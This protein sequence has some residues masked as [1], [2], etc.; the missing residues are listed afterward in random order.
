MSTHAKLNFEGESVIWMIPKQTLQNTKLTYETFAIQLA[1]RIPKLKKEMPKII[2]I[3]YKLVND[4]AY[5]LMADDADIIKETLTIKN[6]DMFYI[7][8]P[9]A[10]NLHIFNAPNNNNNNN[11]ADAE[12]EAKYNNADIK[13]INYINNQI[14]KDSVKGLPHQFDGT[15]NVNHFIYQFK[16]YFKHSN[17]VPIDYQCALLVN[18]QAIIG[19]AREYLHQQLSIQNNEQNINALEKINLIWTILKKRYAIESQYDTYKTEFTRI[20]QLENEDIKAYLDRFDKVFHKLKLEITVQN[21]LGCN[22]N[23]PTSY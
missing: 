3:N 2:T 21:E 8:N 15:G 13:N 9:K 22:F 14:I 12:N 17:I 4:K 1:K 6:I 23:T 19:D 20:E 10:T 16:Q 18:N 7:N 11:N 5:Y